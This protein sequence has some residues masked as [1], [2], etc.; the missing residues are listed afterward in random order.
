[1]ACFLAN[2]H[3]TSIT[4]PN[5]QKNDNVTV[6]LIM[7]RVGN[8]S[9]TVH[10]RYNDFVEL[11][12]KLVSDHGVA[13]DILPPKKVIGN[14]DPAF[15]EKRRGALEV[16]IASVVNFLQ[17]T[18]P[19]ELALFLDFHLYDIL[20]L[21]QNLAMQFFLDGDTLL[22][23]SKSYTFNPFQLHAISERLKQPCPPL[24][25]LDNR[26]DFSHVLD[27]CC[28]LT[29]VTIKGCNEPVGTSNIIPNNLQF[30]LSAFKT[31]QRL[32]LIGFPVSNIFSIG[33]M[34][35]T[36]TTLNVHNAELRQITQVLLCDDLHKDVIYTGES[37]SW[38]KIV[39]ANFSNNELESIDEGVKLMPN[40]EHLTLSNNKI[41]ALSNLTSLPHLSYLNLSANTFTEV[42]DFHT[43][44]GNIRYIDLSLNSITSLQGFS[45]LYSL[46]GLDLTSNQISD[47][48][49]IK[50]VSNL[51][52]LENLTL[53]GNPVA[54]VVDYRV[55]ALEQFGHRA[56]E[57]CLDNEKPSQKELDT[58]AVLQAIRIVKEGRTPTFGPEAPTFP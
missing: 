9:W 18:I 24:E 41:G 28:Q 33:I 25:I 43:K 52:C 38:K 37:H 35:N 21:L 1:M 50:H 17:R 19:R 4:I 47:L 48:L 51:P 20:F 55:R 29:S 27:F 7:V 42:I 54:I 56:A 15:I 10:H 53:T 31:I 2:R 13:K 6:Y 57:I 30:E 49:E 36:V 26:Y 23:I 34:R 3:D 46:E 39:E 45:K 14:R 16:Y 44:L 5:V 58:V 22:Q 40:I 12:E 11:H 8:V 32:N